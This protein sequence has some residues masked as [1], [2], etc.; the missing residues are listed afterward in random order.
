MTTFVKATALA[1]VAAV[2]LAGAASAATFS[3]LDWSEQGT[4]NKAGIDFAVGYG[5]HT[6]IGA[7]WD[8]PDVVINVPPGND[9]G[10][11]Q[12][13]FNSN[14][15]TETVDY[16]STQPGGGPGLG[17]V[18]PV[19]LS[20][21]E[22]QQAF[23]MLWGSI[24]SYNSVTFKLGG[25]DVY[26]LGGNAVAGAIGLDPATNYEVVALVK[27]LDFES[28]F[29]SITFASTS[30]ALEFALAPIPLPAAGWLLLA[31]LGGLGVVA[32]RKKA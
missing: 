24:D 16:F 25:S 11:F 13:P 29:D 32:R 6:P 31:G 10:D 28:G 9:P 27:F 19:T 15:L 30:A 17:A 4:E 23:T 20:F 1:A 22:V 12:S 18:S 3:V 2:G 21:T 14:G 26:T 8:K 7:S 5:A